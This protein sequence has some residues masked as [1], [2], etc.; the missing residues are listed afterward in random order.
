MRI[1]TIYLRKGGLISIVNLPTF[2]VTLPA[3]DGE[4]NL[5]VQFLP[6][7]IKIFTDS[8]VIKSNDPD[9]SLITVR[10]SGQG[11]GTGLTVDDSD[12]T[13]YIFPADV[14]NWVGTP[15]PLNL[16][17]WYRVSGSGINLQDYSHIFISTRQQDCKQLN[18]IRISQESRAV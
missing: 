7:S 2:P 14:Q 5:V 8:L 16:D 9:D 12:P 11:V 15:D 4:L 3:I 18:G 6:D 10:V 13:T 17:K 1:D